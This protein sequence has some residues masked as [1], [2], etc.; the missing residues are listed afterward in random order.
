[1]W[2]LFLLSAAHGVTDLSQGALLVALPYFK[3]KFGL[4]YAQVS[5]IALVQN[6]TSSVSQ[7]LFGYFT[8]RKS[9]PWLMPAGC[10]LSGAAMVASLLAPAYWLVLTFTAL[11]GFGVAAFHP[12]GAKSANR[13]SGAAKG[14]GVSLF[15]VGGNAG[16]AVGSLFMAFLLADDRA[17][18]LL[19][20]LLP[21]IVLAVLL[22]RLTKLLPRQSPDRV[23]VAGGLKAAVSSPVLIILGIVFLRATVTAGIS[24]FLPLYYVSFLHGDPLYAS[25]LLTVYLAGGAVGTLFGGILSDRLGSKRVMVWSILPVSVLLFMFKSVEGWIVFVVLVVASALLSAAFASSL[26]LAQN[27]LPGNVGMASG[28]TIGF[29]VGLGAMGVLALG[30]VADS[31]GLPIVFDVLTVLPVAAFVLALFMKEPAAC[32]EPIPERA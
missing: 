32:D 18:R 31:Y 11:C 22:Y 24:T 2:P 10:F 5:A 25:S 1:M 13:L 20:Y 8:D 3:A 7:P 21:F 14:K 19:L 23:A 12:E 17:D 26:V 9:R 6:L 4:S 27:M 15:A 28:L 30:R 16:F 29:S